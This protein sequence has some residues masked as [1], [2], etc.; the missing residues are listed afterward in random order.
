MAYTP[1]NLK[2]GVASAGWP[3]F[4]DPSNANY[5]SLTRLHAADPIGGYNHLLAELK[6]TQDF[7]LDWG[8]NLVSVDAFGRALGYTS[9]TNNWKPAIDAAIAHAVAARKRIVHLSRNYPIS[10]TI[11][12]PRHIC[13]VANGG[14][15]GGGA[16]SYSPDPLTSFG[17]GLR[18]FMMPANAP[19]LQIGEGK[20]VFGLLLSGDISR[21]LVKFEIDGT[22]EPGG[23]AYDGSNSDGLYAHNY[24]I[25]GNG[26]VL[27]R[28]NVQGWHFHNNQFDGS[29]GYCLWVDSANGGLFDNNQ[30]IGNRFFLSLDTNAGD[31]NVK[32]ENCWH[33]IFVGNY[34]DLNRQGLYGLSL[35]RSGQNVFNDT[36]IGEVNRG[37]RILDCPGAVNPLYG[38]SFNELGN[39][40]FGRVANEHVTIDAS[41]HLTFG[42]L[43]FGDFSDAV[44]GLTVQDTY[45]F[46]TLNTCDKIHVLRMLLSPNLGKMKVIDLSAGTTKTVTETLIAPVG[47]T[48]F[49]NAG[50]ATNLVGRTIQ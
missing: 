12:V 48:T 45:C 10:D 37:V 38:Q 29:V 5:G 13:L 9:S 18:N 20:G 41:N 35:T 28:D 21:P 2:E 3:T 4:Q 43:H 16:H 7:V 26:C 6:A 27:I 46:R 30:V 34:I 36:I 44:S 8:T 23:S 39:I 24:H 15:M 19:L 1:S 33:N 11:Y 25:G 50:G 22:K 17:A 40:T 32:L 42:S 14:T 47:A 31:I 49:T